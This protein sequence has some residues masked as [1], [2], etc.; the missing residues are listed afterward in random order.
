MGR[1]SAGIS[2]A[3]F[4]SLHEVGGA[5]SLRAHSP[6]LYLPTENI[7]PFYRRCLEINRELLNCELCAHEIEVVGS[8]N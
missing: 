3:V 1:R 6:I 2:A 4:I 5:S 8:S 7:L